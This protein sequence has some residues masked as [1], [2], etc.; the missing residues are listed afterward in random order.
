MLLQWHSFVLVVHSRGALQVI[1]GHPLAS[2]FFLEADEYEGYP[3]KV[4]VM[5]AVVGFISL[6]TAVMVSILSERKGNE[7]NWRQ[8][9]APF[10]TKGLM[11][12]L[13]AASLTPCMKWRARRGGLGKE[14]NLCMEK[15]LHVWAILFAVGVWLLIALNFGFDKE[16]AKSQAPGQLFT[17]EANLDALITVVMNYLV[18]EQV[19]TLFAFLT[20]AAGMLDA[21]NLGDI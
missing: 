19:E 5:H 20:G 8:Y 4:R 10:A 3:K 13:D 21:F 17:T 14:K 18:I 7:T 11:Y 6:L 12:I 9:S 15:W 1:R 2:I 16:Q